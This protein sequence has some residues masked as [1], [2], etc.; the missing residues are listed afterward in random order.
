[1][2]IEMAFCNEFSRH[3]PQSRTYGG[4][5]FQLTAIVRLA[6]N[7]DFHTSSRDR[8]PG[9]LASRERVT[10]PVRVVNHWEEKSS[11]CANDYIVDIR[12]VPIM[13]VSDRLGTRGEKG[14]LRCA[15]IRPNEIESTDVVVIVWV[16]IQ[17][18][19]FGRA[20]CVQII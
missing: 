9:V 15:A 1:M 10:H 4:Y 8:C 13:D 16:L 12:V 6:G 14:A 11:S 17:M 2:A 19:G 3:R 5:L 18:L 7:R 20:S